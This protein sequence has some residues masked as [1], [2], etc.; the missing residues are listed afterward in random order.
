MKV[1]R[2]RLRARAV[3]AAAVALALSA[4]CLALSACGRSRPAA[5]VAEAKTVSVARAARAT[6]SVSL[7][8]SARIRP[9]QEIVVSPK[10]AGRIASVRADVSQRVRRGQ[11]L[12]TLESTDAETQARQARAALDSARA[13]LTRTSDSSLSS[14]LI[15]A[16][17]AV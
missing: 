5:P 17:A 10:V 1:T 12:F 3:A 4:A 16:Q 2:P 13:N 11:V 14:Q 9:K 6:I 7:D 8:Y 15:Q